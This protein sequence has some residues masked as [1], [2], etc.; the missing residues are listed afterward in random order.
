MKW[1][2]SWCVP[3]FASESFAPYGVGRHSS[4]RGFL[5]ALTTDLHLSLTVA[6]AAGMRLQRVESTE[7]RGAGAKDADAERL[8]LLLETQK[9]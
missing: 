7:R 6:G 4:R 9:G 3:A 5:E 8:K 2:I 1:A